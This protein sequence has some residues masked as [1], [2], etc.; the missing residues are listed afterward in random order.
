MKWYFG[1]LR[2]YATF[3]GRARRKEYWSFVFLNMLVGCATALLAGALGILCNPS[4]LGSA[5][6]RMQIVTIFSSL[7]SLVYSLL[8]FL[9]SVAV[10]VRRMHDGGRSGWWLFVPFINFILLFLGSQPHD[11]EYGPNPTV[12]KPL[13]SAVQPA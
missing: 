7:G 5:D 12:V 6:E 1:V 2:K 9:P 10:A 4:S 13:R 11:N 8:V 3:K